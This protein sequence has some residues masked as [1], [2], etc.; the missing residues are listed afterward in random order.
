MLHPPGAGQR[1]TKEA[2]DVLFWLSLADDTEDAPWMVMGDL[3]FRSAST[4]FH[5]LSNY[6]RE[7]RL[8]WYV[9]SM[10]PIQYGKL[11][12]CRKQTFAPDLIVALVPDHPRTSFD[13]NSEGGFPPF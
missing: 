8:P 12:S 13:V 6:A 5:S 7:Q 1:V 9:A 11:P 10:L 4:L 3:Q 2:D